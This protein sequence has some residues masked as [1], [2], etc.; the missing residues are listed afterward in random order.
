MSGDTNKP[1]PEDPGK[2]KDDHKEK[3]KE[4]PPEKP[5]EQ[6]VPLILHTQ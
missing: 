2:R 1:K 6:P 5:E 4:R 3:P